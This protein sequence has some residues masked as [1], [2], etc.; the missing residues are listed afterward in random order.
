V[1]VEPAV[2]VSS[3]AKPTTKAYN[4]AHSLLSLTGCTPASNVVFSWIF[5]Q[6]LKGVTRIFDSI[7]NAP[8]M[9][10]IE[11]ARYAS[12]LVE[13]LTVQISPRLHERIISSVLIG[14]AKLVYFNPILSFSH[15]GSSSKSSSSVIGEWRP[16]E[17][18]V[19]DQFDTNDFQ[20]RSNWLRDLNQGCHWRL[21][22]RA[23]SALMRLLCGYAFPHH[24]QSRAS[25][26]SGGLSTGV[27]IS[28]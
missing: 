1:E 12:K 11:G 27:P 26:G 22:P 24:L 8:N 17:S 25:G 19:G 21:L 20:H 14:S 18:H 7:S 10:W 28:A 23:L 2:V 15:D 16:C 4:F 13:V 3:P 6:F 9:I 5:D